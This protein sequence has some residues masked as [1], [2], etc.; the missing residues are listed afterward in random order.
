M[1]RKYNKYTIEQKEKALSLYLEGRGIDKGSRGKWTLKE[2]QAM[3]G[4]H[5]GMIYKYANP[6]GA[7]V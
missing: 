5:Y 4:V 1:Q 6:M 7:G 2:I 3:T